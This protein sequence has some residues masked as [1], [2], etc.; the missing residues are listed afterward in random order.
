M[1]TKTVEAI[2]EPR[3]KDRRSYNKI[4]DFSFLTKEGVALKERRHYI[5]RRIRDKQVIWFLA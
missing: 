5:D 2:M 1:D 4:P 3:M